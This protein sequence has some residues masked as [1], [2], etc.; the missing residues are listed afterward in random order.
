T[1]P[2]NS[3]AETIGRG[4]RRL[5][6][7]HRAVILPVMV[8]RGGERAFTRWLGRFFGAGRGVRGPVG[9]D[10]AGGVNRA[11]QS[12]LCSGP[13]SG[14]GH[15]DGAADLA[16]VG[17]KAVNRNLADLAAM[18][19]IADWLLVSLVLPPR[20]S[21]KGRRRL[22]VGIRA[23]AAAGGCAVVGGDVASSRGPLT[24][25]VTA[26]GHCRGR[27]LRRSG[28]RAGDAIH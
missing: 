7:A 16:L 14:G 15:L 2:P 8:A 25:T 12:V 28:A 17:R 13:G 19:A 3:S 21:P 26:V 22:L 27:V 6:R 5:Q 18:G 10:A 4:A 1:E 11:A 24:V 9:D 23:A 20:L